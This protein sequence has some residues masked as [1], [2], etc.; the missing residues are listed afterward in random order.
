MAKWLGS[1]GCSDNKA[2]VDLLIRDRAKP[3]NVAQIPED[4]EVMIVRVT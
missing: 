2:L 1:G 4:K 3:E